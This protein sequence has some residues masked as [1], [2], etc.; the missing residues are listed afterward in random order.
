MP[1]TPVISPG[2]SPGPGGA[3]PADHPAGDL[4]AGHAGAAAPADYTARGGACAR[5]LGV[6]RLK[7]PKP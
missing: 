5:P 7:T 1:T 3:A 4:A 6:S 2:I